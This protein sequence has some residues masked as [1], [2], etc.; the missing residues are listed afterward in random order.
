MKRLGLNVVRSASDGDAAF[1]HGNDGT[2]VSGWLFL[3]E[4]NE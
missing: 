3:P 2:W 4:E 1:S